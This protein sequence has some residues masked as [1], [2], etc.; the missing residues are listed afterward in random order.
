MREREAEAR[1]R[2]EAVNAAEAALARDRQAREESAERLTEMRVRRATIM[3]AQLT[4][5][6]AARNAAEQLAG[7]QLRLENNTAGTALEEK[8]IAALGESIA[9]E[10]AELVAVRARHAGSIALLEESRRQ[11]AAMLEAIAAILEEQK[12]ARGA[13]EECQGRVHRTELRIAQIEAE[14]GF[15]EG[16]FFDDYR[17]TPDQALAQA[18]PVNDRGA[19]V[20]RLKEQQAALE[21]L[22]TVNLG[23]I[24]EFDAHRRA[25]ELPDPAAA[26]PGGEAGQP[27]EGHRGDRPDLPGEV[28]GRL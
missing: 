9:Q 3:A 1:E 5:Y 27:D 15:L 14:V 12:S 26:R 17:L 8:R 22:G 10:E 23:A 16:Q 4:Q 19:A 20:F 7:L 6:E 2:E 28:P 21:A 24:E 11:R 25:A 13:G 18:E